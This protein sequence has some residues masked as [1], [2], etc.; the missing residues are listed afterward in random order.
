VSDGPQWPQDLEQAAALLREVP[1]DDAPEWFLALAERRR[2][3]SGGVR[4]DWAWVWAAE[5]IASFH[6][7]RLLPFLTALRPIPVDRKQRA[8]DTVGERLAVGLVEQPTLAECRAAIS[9]ADEAP[10]R[11]SIFSKSPAP[12]DV[13][14]TLVAV[15]LD[16]LGCAEESLSRTPETATGP[17]L[18]RT[19]SAGP[20]HRVVTSRLQ[21]ATCTVQVERTEEFV[22]GDVNQPASESHEVSVN[23]RRG[24][25]KLTVKARVGVRDLWFDVEAVSDERDRIL[26]KLWRAFG[27]PSRR[28]EEE[29]KW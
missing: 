13:D 20:Q 12:P 1:I 2:V 15:V 16:A 8:L 21:S 25:T 23:G 29:W 22:P 4:E 26:A 5:V 14:A 18:D 11:R 28:P 9:E 27:R 24:G 17:E 19:D 10:R 3:A 7:E 6:P